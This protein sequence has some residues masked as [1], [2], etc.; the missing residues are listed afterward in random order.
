MQGGWKARGGGGERCDEVVRGVGYD[1]TKAREEEAEVPVTG[2]HVQ[3]DRENMEG[4]AFV[5]DCEGRGQ[6]S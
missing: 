5:R 3:G 4:W 2:G 1:E 6:K